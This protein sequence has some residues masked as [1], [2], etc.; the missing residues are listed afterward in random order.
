MKSVLS[1]GQCAADH[2][3]L[4]RL[5]RS[6]FAVEVTAVAT[7]EQALTQMRQGGIALVLVNRILDYDGSSGLDFIARIKAEEKLRDVPVMLVSNHEDA[8]QEALA[9]G[10]LPGFGK[11]ALYDPETL[12]RVRIVLGNGRPEGEA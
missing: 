7:S 2:S 5:L 3:A 9:R 12:D 8:Q 1:L 4:N 6:E 11:G 10:A